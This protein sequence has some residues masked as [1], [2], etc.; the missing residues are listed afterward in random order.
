MLDLQEDI[1]AFVFKKLLIRKNK[2]KRNFKHRKLKAYYKIKAKIQLQNTVKI[3]SEK[4]WMDDCM[5]V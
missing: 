4:F 5:S 1:L 2:S 3:L